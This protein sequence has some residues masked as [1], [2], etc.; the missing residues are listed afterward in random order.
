[1]TVCDLKDGSR[2][3]EENVKFIY[4]KFDIKV[5]QNSEKI[6][7]NTPLKSFL[8]CILEG[9]FLEG[10]IFLK[11]ENFNLDQLSILSVPTIVQI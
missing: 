6:L 3:F 5:S 11:G 2:S 4:T 8:S 7:F 1:M 10:L 9:V